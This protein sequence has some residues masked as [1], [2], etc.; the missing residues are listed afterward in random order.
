MTIGISAAAL[1]ALAWGLTFVKTTGEQL[2]CEGWNTRAFFMAATGADV[3]RCLED[4]ANIE[5]QDEDGWTPLHVAAAFEQSPAAVKTLLAA[6]ADIEAKDE[7]GWTA[8]HVAARF[9]DSPAVVKAPCLLVG[10][11]LRPSRGC[12]STPTICVC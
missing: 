3:V 7:T 12:L 8:L 5:A 9:S 10:P 2:S 6:A 1:G 11:T 4:G